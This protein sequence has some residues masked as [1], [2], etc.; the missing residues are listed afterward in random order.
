MLALTG[1]ASV[2]QTTGSTT[3]TDTAA[4]IPY[5]G[6]TTATMPATPAASLS[7]SDFSLLG[8]W[9]G[10]PA[11]P[12]GLRECGYTTYGRFTASLVQVRSVTCPA[13]A[14]LI[15][16]YVSRRQAPSGWTLAASGAA[17]GQA[18]TILTFQARRGSGFVNFKLAGGAGK[19]PTPVV[20]GAVDAVRFGCPTRSS[21]CS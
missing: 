19:P 6:S 8:V 12:P 17:T 7:R 5:P 14:Q 4:P 20:A 15:D 16:S 21:I 1:C 10:D 2:V 3:G 18:E 11:G 9:L 13:A